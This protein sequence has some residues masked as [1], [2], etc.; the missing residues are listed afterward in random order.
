MDRKSLTSVFSKVTFSTFN[1]L[2]KYTSYSFAVTFFS[3]GIG[4]VI[5]TLFALY[6]FDAV[7]IKVSAKFLLILKVLIGIVWMY[8]LFQYGLFKKLG[9]SGFGKPITD[10]NKHIETYPT[11]K[12]NPNLQ[13]SEYKRLL[14]SLKNFPSF[15]AMNTSIGVLVVILMAILISI[16]TEGGLNWLFLFNIMIVGAI[17]S[18]I[19]ICFSLIVGEI[20]TGDVRVQCKK[21]M[22]ERGIRFHD[23]AMFSVKLKLLFLLV[24]FIITLFLSNILTYFNRDEMTKVFSFAFLAVIV[25][26]IMAYLLFRIIYTS[27]KQIEKSSQELIK[28][29]SGILFPRSLDKEFLNLS[30]SINTAVRTIRDYQSSLEEKVKARTSELNSAVE[31]LARKDKMIETELDFAAD[32]QRGIIPWELKPWNGISFAAYYQPMGKVSGDYFDIFRFHDS[33]FVLMADASGHGVPAALITMTAKQAFSTVIKESMKPAE[34]FRSVNEIMVE[35]LKTSDYLSAFM[36]KIDQKNRVTFSNA[37]HPKAIHYIHSRDE[38]IL[39]DTNGIFIGAIKEAEDS[40]ENQVTRLKSG[41]RIFLYTDGVL[42]HKNAAGEQFGLDRTIEILAANK[43]QTLDIQVQKLMESLRNF[44]GQGSIKDDISLI[45]LELE[46]RWSQFI[47]LYNKGIKFLK[48]K[49]LSEALGHFSEAYKLIPSFSNIQLQLAI[50]YYHMNELVKAEELVS[51]YLK[52]KPT[53]K[54]GIQ[55]AI[56]VFMKQNKKEEANTLLKVLKSVSDGEG[57]VP[58]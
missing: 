9:F 26:M 12:I 36:L 32:I 58:S 20:Y 41:D 5:A 45:A 2:A 42:E 31:A 51:Y 54:M 16:V 57:K 7:N 29:G 23:R 6:Y 43:K 47:E 21:L 17:A 28:G 55:L 27:L 46:P 4:A 38:Y 34:I 40:Y 50:V 18:F 19:V 25:S 8:M 53:D 15:I 49:D 39:L 1:F 11:I 14:R 24:L 35:R 44:I 13:P 10:A 3:T 52:E 37:A 56:N 33:I 48:I 22:Y 30:K